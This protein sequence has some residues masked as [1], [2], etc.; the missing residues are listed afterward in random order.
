MR[1]FS[2]ESIRA[3]RPIVH[4]ARFPSPGLARDPVHPLLLAFGAIVLWSSFAALGVRLA[5]TPPFLL[6]GIA[7]LLGG[8]MALP[9]LARWEFS[10]RVI[11]LGVYGVF[12]YHFALF[13]ALRL[14]P[15]VEA[16]LLNYL[17][18]LLI[19]VLTPV[20][21]P[22][23]RLAPRHVAAGAMGFAG[24]AILVTGA[25]WS[26]EPGRVAGYGLAI[27][28][29]VV[30]ATY[31]LGTRRMRDFSTETVGLF[32]LVAG[33]LGLVCHFAFEAPHTVPVADWPW[34]AVL[35]LGPCGAAFYLWD[36]AL[37]R[38]DP[39]GI[40]ALAYLTPLFSTAILA[41]TTGGEVG[42]RSV[43]AL[44]LIVAG[45]VV[46]NWRGTPRVT[47]PTASAGVRTPPTD[48]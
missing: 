41:G 14:A 22:G 30:W 31:S 15:A 27:A 28:A 37:K 4:D 35:G 12:C 42:P 9:R 18:P 8:A 1:E 3:R 2:Q 40:G 46:G 10:P 26:L 13:S 16:N 24:T 17:W 20:F 39:R 38:G 25:D 7:L 43:I 19:V 5:G 11:A 34:L 44:A 6:V 47:A 45:A 36:A 21:L 32:C 23:T 29:A 33:A 48:R